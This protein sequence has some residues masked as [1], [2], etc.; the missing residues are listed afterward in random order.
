LIVNFKYKIEPNYTK[1]DGRMTGAFKAPGLCKRT[2]MAVRSA[3]SL[4]AMDER[5]MEFYG[6]GERA[7]S[8][9]VKKLIGK[10]I[11]VILD[12]PNGD[13]GRSAKKFHVASKMFGRL[14]EQLKEKP[15]G[16]W[17]YLVAGN[18]RVK[19]LLMEAH[20]LRKTGKFKESD[21]AY[22]KAAAKARELGITEKNVYEL[23][24][25][26]LRVSSLEPI[27]RLREKLREK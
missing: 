15:F 6:W 27:H 8:E 20:V 24:G 19:A 5:G 18:N 9:A 13:F 25:R 1:G 4:E 11:D 3:W 12:T 16:H 2:A 21:E 7:K 23:L 14:S 17:D 22:G 10:H 26:G